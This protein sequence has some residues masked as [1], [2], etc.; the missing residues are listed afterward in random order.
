MSRSLTQIKVTFH[1]PIHPPGES[2]IVPF[3]VAGIVASPFGIFRRDTK[4]PDRGVESAPL[5]PGPPRL[6]SVPEHLCPPHRLP[7]PGR[8]AGASGGR[9][10]RH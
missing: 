2:K 5:L 7:S 9:L 1:V 10:V 4:G 3:P 6:R 8:R